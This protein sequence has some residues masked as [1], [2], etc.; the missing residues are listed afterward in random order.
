VKKSL[1]SLVMSEMGKKGGKI[2]GKR[3]PGDDDTG[4]ELRAGEDRVNGRSEETHSGSFG[5]RTSGRK[6]QVSA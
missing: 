4:G 6:A 2:G 3:K 1:I 5:A